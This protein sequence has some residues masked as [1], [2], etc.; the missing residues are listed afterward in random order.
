MCKFHFFCLRQLKIRKVCTQS[1]AVAISKSNKPLEDAKNYQPIFLLRIL[2]KIF[3]RP[4]YARIEPI[5]DHWLPHEQAGFT[6]KRLIAHQIASMTQEMEDCF[7]A[8]KK[9]GA[10]FVD[11]TTA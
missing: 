2:C 7:L 9:A 1:L 3:E 4:L 5:I 10:V 11:L 8:K 6:R